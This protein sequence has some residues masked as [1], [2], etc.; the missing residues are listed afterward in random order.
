[1]ALGDNTRTAYLWVNHPTQTGVR[2][3]ITITQDEQAATTNATAAT[4]NATAATTG[5]TI[6]TGSGGAGGRGRRDTPMASAAIAPARADALRAAV[7]G[8][9]A[10]PDHQAGVVRR[11]QAPGDRGRG[12]AFEVGVPPAFLDSCFFRCKVKQSSFPGFKLHQPSNWVLIFSHPF[13]SYVIIH[14]IVS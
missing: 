5:A 3:K 8:A 14:D 2:A 4:T 13:I 10:L 12:G 1:M 7:A 9:A 6:N 11:P